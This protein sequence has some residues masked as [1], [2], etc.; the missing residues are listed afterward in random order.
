MTEGI[1]TKLI[2]SRLIHANA[3]A[4]LYCMSISACVMIQQWYM[5]NNYQR[6]W[7]GLLVLLENI[8]LY[9]L[10]L[11]ATSLLPAF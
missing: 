9:G 2:D 4:V 10:A 5:F 1:F 6:V 8:F 7:K 3:S 11:G